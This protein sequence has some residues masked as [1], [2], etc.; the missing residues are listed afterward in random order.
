MI[1][2][3]AGALTDWWL[4]PPPLSPVPAMTTDR[5]ST[6]LP[7]AERSLGTTGVELPGLPPVDEAPSVVEELLRKD[8][9]VPV[10][11]ADPVGW[12]GAFEQE[13]A[14]HEHEAVDILA[15][16]GTPVLAVD[17]GVVAKMFT[18]RNGGITLYQFDPTR[19]FTYYYAHLDR[20]ADGIR[21]GDALS[22]GQ[23]IGYVGTT[24]NA[25]PDT[26]HLHFAIFQLADGDGWWQGRPIDP[27]LAYGGDQR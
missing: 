2:F 18:S 22:R 4:T 25:P 14:G 26:P 27:Y 24:G 3:A 11:G 13:R 6:D 12:K 15:P 21:E 9:L 10:E 5:G 17:E 19:Q 20:Y 8:L 16:R 7:A 1:G 23:V